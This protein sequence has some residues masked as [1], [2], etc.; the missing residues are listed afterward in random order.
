MEMHAEHLQ[1]KSII[2][3]DDNNLIGVENKTF[4]NL[5]QD[6]ISKGS[7]I[8]SVDLSKVKYIASLG[9]ESLVH[10]Y[11]TCTKRNIQFSIQGV[12]EK[13]MNVLHQVKLDTIL[14]IT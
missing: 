9:I 6:S 5:V 13:V 10:A 4:Q 8:I 3:V 7:K 2:V 11:T 12:S 14:I 1:G